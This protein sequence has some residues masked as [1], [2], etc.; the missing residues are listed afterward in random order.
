[1]TQPDA[2]G[3]A[4]VGRPPE[5]IAVVLASAGR[6]QLLGDVIE[7]LGRQT[8]QDF[9]L[10]VSTPDEASLPATPLPPGAV[11]VHDRGLAA[12]RNAGLAAVPHATHVFCFDDD[13]V[14]RADFIEQ[15]MLFFDAHPHVVALTGRVLLDGAAA[16]E[17]PADVAAAELAASAATPGTGTWTPSRTLYGCNFAFRPPAV[18]GEVFD[19]RLPLYSWLEDHD[20]ARRLMRKGTLAIVDDCVI[21]HRGVKSGGRTAHVRLGYSQVMNPAYLHHKG[22]FPLWLTVHE[23]VFRCGKNVVRSVVGQ[24]TQWRRERLRGNVRAARDVLRGRF[25]PE[26]ILDIPA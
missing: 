5:S 23:T 1:M 8:R 14:V 10:V 17:V 22:S 15:A 12:Q 18:G 4:E 21:V 9:T 24:E 13:A 3:S 26:R 16:E 2:V 20:F 19:A 25:T 11:L 7:G 6:P